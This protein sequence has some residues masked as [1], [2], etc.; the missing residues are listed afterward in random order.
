M[1]TNS[2]ICIQRVNTHRRKAEAIYGLENK[3]WL[4]SAEGFEDVQALITRTKGYKFRAEKFMRL[5][6]D[7]GLSL[8]APNKDSRV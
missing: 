1:L 6:T 4:K 3:V 7:R 8:P 2:C 5:I